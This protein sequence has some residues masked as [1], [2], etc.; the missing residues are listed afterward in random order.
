MK[1]LIVDDQRSMRIVSSAVVKGLGHE[2][3]EASSGQ[4][5]IELCQEQKIDLILMD[6]EMPGMDGFETT[7]VIRS[8]SS[9]WF[10]IIFVSAMTD[11]SFF[12]EGIR[13]GGDIY[14]FKPI[15]KEVLES[16]INAMHRIAKNQDELHETKLKMEL[17]A[18]QDSL[19]GLVNRRGFDNAIGLDIK[20]A[21][22][23]KSPL[24]LVMMDIDHFK[25]YNDEY[26][27]PKGDACLVDV[28]KVLKN[29]VCR[30]RD[31]VARY[32][33]EEFS[34]ILPGTTAEH[35]ET[36]LKRIMSSLEA[37]HIP[38]GSSDVSD[39]ITLSCGVSEWRP[40]QTAGELI[41]E[42]DRALYLAKENGRNRYVFAS[43]EA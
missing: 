17:L 39:R 34:L 31:I 38:H 35:A 1:V 42:A 24:T 14:L 12:A 41:E 30:P 19:T 33:G 4:E 3:V 32:G 22:R 36:V 21:M 27:H 26:G 25:A 8:Q 18:H 9:I 43:E 40:G 16:M 37:L 6:V 7:K 20:Q 23:E 2:V 15:I 11:S 28:A 13:S 10:P 29:G 5:A